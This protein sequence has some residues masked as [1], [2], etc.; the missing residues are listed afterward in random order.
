[1]PDREAT[2]QQLADALPR[3]SAAN[4]ERLLR[5][6]GEMGGPKALETIAAVLQQGDEML[7]DAAT[8]VLG[9][10]MSVDAAPV[11]MNLAKNPANE[12]YRVRAARLHSPRAAVRHER[13]AA[14]R[15][16]PAGV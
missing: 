8:R 14:S 3:A 12:K 15:N 10:W 1:M 5:I 6:L 13:R 2:A 4:Q 7:D 16:V 9:Q 11:L